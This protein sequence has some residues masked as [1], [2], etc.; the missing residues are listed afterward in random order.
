M[1]FQLREA[2]NHYRLLSILDSVRAVTSMGMHAWALTQWYYSYSTPNVRLRPWW[3]CT[4]CK[5]HRATSSCRMFEYPAC[6]FSCSHWYTSTS[7]WESKLLF[8]LC[9]GCRMSIVTKYPGMHLG[10]LAT[11]I[12]YTSIAILCCGTWHAATCTL[13]LCSCAD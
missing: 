12:Y 11:C 4:W 8:E 13:H 2:A 7:S 3:W 6:S 1:F 5:G 10:G 9:M